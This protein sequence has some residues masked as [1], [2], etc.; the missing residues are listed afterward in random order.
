MV[1]VVAAPVSLE[2]FTFFVLLELDDSAIFKLY[3]KIFQK[4]RICLKILFQKI[5]PIKSA[6][7][8]YLKKKI[9]NKLLKSML[10]NVLLKWCVSLIEA[11]Q[12]RYF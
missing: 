3:F 5:K 9:L 4:T 1:L 6:C 7:F 8:L 11:L 12:H 2:R 10:Q